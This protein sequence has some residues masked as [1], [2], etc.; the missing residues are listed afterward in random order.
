MESPWAATLISV[1]VVSLASLAGVV[2][3]VLGAGPLRRIVFWLVSFAAGTLLG[4]VF[5][6]LLPEAVER[7][8]MSMTVSLSICGGI[9]LFFLLEK[10]LAWR[11][12]HLP[13][14]HEHPHRLSTM[15]LVG[16]GL[17]NLLDGLIIGAAYVA[18]FKLGLATTVAVLLH[19]IPQEI[20]DMGVL[21]YSGMSRRKAILFN[22]LTACAAFVGAIVAVALGPALGDHLREVLL[23]LTAGA[24]IYIAG[25]DLIPELHKETSTPAAM[26]QF[27]LF[28]GGLA[29]ML[30]LRFLPFAH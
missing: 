10:F 26:G 25:S 2:T 6:H 5:L 15:N 14:T 11:H 23:P 27:V 28:A 16:D 13:S 7:D 17:H 12:C 22:G 4:G 9:L 1:A 20:A 29:L 3:F 8:G 18:D 19:E 30:G 24:F 21:L